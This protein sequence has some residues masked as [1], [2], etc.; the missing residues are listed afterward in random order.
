MEEACACNTSIHTT[1]WSCLGEELALIKIKPNE[2]DTVGSEFARVSAHFKKYLDP[3]FLDNY[4][5]EVEG[6]EIS[7]DTPM[8]E[9]FRL[10]GDL[11]IFKITD[12]EFADTA[13]DKEEGEYI[14]SDTETIETSDDE[15]D[16]GEL[17][18][19]FFDG[20]KSFHDYC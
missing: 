5:I 18:N 4:I 17:E 3:D 19:C 15:G 6:R 14:G 10:Y 12:P 8:R 13:S 1:W 9:V 7:K 16:Y 2:L 20:T 11:P